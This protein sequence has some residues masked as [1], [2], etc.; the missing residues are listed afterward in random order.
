[1]LDELGIEMTV[2]VGPDR[3]VPDNFCEYWNDYRID[4]PGL[5]GFLDQWLVPG[6]TSIE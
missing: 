4:E 5:A 2:I 6:S 1:V 3:P